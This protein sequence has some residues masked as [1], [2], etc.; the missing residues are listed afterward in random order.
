MIGESYDGGVLR[1]EEYYDR[2]YMG[3]GPESMSQ[4]PE[5]KSQGPESK[6]Q[7]PEVRAR[8]Q[9]VRARAQKANTPRSEQIPRK[10]PAH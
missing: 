9:K 2:R 4:G 1:G 7:G 8:A 3:Q 10:Y 6:S 5:S